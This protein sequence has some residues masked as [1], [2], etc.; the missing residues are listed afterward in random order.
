MYRDKLAIAPTDVTESISNS[1]SVW[2]QFCRKACSKHTGIMNNP[3]IQG[4]LDL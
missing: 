1:V 2:K 3:L 4:E